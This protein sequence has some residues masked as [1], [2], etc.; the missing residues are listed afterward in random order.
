MLPTFRQ[1]FRI[2]VLLLSTPVLLPLLRCGRLLKCS[3]RLLTSLWGASRVTVIWFQLKKRRFLLIGPTI[4]IPGLK[5]MVGNTL[6]SVVARR[7]PVFITVD[8]LFL[9]L[10][11]R[12]MIGRGGPG[13][14]AWFTFRRTCARGRHPS[15]RCGRGYGRGVRGLTWR[16]WRGC[17][18][19]RWYRRPILVG[20]GTRPGFITRVTVPALPVKKVLL[21]RCR[22]KRF[23]L[24]CR[25]FMAFMTFRV[26]RLILIFK[27]TVGDSGVVGCGFRG[28]TWVFRF[29]TLVGF[30]DQF[31]V[32]RFIPLFWRCLIFVPAC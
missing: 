23:L 32:F 3:R 28:Q 29:H 22:P 18:V 6:F 19:R 20:C 31:P 4:I 10:L 15:W 25:P 26:R 27:R 16:R 12:F 17:R 11:R 14:T 1:I 21:N 2:S 5:L 13:Q 7:R 9:I 24:R 30:G 8:R